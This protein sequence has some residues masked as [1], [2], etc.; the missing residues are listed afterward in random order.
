MYIK[1]TV[2]RKA[3]DKNTVWGLERLEIVIQEY[4][5]VI[6]AYRIRRE[7]DLSCITVL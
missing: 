1:L 2:I 3:Y 7:R 5:S 6:Q 4:V